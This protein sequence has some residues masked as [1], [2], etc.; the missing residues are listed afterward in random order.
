MSLQPFRLALTRFHLRISLLITLPPRQ[1]TDLVKDIDRE[2]KRAC[3]NLISHCTRTSTQPL[4]IFL[5]QAGQYLNSRPPSAASSAPAQGQGAN[6]TSDLP[7]QVFAT[8]EKVKEVHDTF[9]SQVGGKVGEWK[10]ELGRYLMDE[11]T[12]GVLVPPANV[13]R[14]LFYTVRQS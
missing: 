10:Q 2:L 13:S 8:P 11:D 3:E 9:R 4:R 12:V 6:Q 14:D 5:D 1:T 7:S